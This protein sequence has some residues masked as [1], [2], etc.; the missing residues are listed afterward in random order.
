MT[1]GIDPYRMGALPIRAIRGGGEVSKFHE[2]AEQSWLAVSRSRSGCGKRPRVTEGGGYPVGPGLIVGAGRVS[3]SAR[4]PVDGGSVAE[5]VLGVERGLAS[6][7][8]GGDR[9]AVVGIDEIA[10][11][12]YAG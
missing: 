3:S 1:T 7:A 11:A 5:V 8:G 4:R 6:G 12:K 2:T 9:L 10:G